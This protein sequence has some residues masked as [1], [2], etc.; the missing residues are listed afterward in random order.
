MKI[1]NGKLQ[2]CRIESIQG[3]PVPFER[4]NEAMVKFTPMLPNRFAH[5]V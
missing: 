5:V 2:S 3:L 4:Y 1:S